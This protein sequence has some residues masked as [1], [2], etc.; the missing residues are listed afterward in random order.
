MKG[1]LVRWA[2]SALS[3]YLTALIAKALGIGIV[4][5]EFWSP[6]L[7]VAAL[8][9]INA[10]IRPLVVIMTLPLNCLT[11]GLLTFIINALMFW[12]AGSGWIPGFKVEGIVPALFGSVVMGIIS[13]IANHL[14]SSRE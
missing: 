13:G 3:L 1:L 14:A 6:F 8:A 12:L 4:I 5:S 2:I 11:L 7:A 9:I 10:L